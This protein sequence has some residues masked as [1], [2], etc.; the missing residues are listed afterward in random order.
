M[1]Y[2]IRIQ[3]EGQAEP[4]MNLGGFSA[5]ETVATVP[6][7][8]Q[9]PVRWFVGQSNTAWATLAINDGIIDVVITAEC[10]HDNKQEHHS[11]GGVLIQC[12]DCQAILGSHA[13]RI[14]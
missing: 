8:V 7:N 6:G 2:H 4:R 1:K 14:Y 11:P 10:Q 9:T 3:D 12:A 13:E 5:T